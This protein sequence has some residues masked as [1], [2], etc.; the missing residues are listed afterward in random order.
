MVEVV[1]T[2]HLFLYFPDLADRPL[3][4]EATTV[5]TTVATAIDA[6]ER[7]APGIAHYLRDETG[8]LRPHVSA[9]IGKELIRDRRTLSDALQPNDRLSLLQALSGG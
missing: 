6:L 5:A 8:R 4:V 7:L 1:L 2:R 3:H 9:F